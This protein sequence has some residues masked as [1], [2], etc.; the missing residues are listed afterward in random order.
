MRPESAAAN[1]FI[2]WKEAR[3]PDDESFHPKGVCETND[4]TLQMCRH[5]YIFM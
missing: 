5:P 4:M 2:G 3:I 1:G